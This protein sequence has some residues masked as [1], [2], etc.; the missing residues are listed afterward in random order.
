MA[1]HPGS[2]GG[3]SGNGTSAAGPQAAPSYLAPLDLA[4]AKQVLSQ[5]R[6][7]NM[8]QNRIIGNDRTPDMNVQAKL[9]AAKLPAAPNKVD[10]QI[11]TGS[12]VHIGPVAGG[13]FSTEGTSNYIVFGVDSFLPSTSGHNAA[14]G[15]TGGV[16][17]PTGLSGSALFVINNLF[18]AAPTVAG[19]ALSASSVSFGYSYLFTNAVNTE[20]YA[21]SRE[22]NLYC[23]TLPTLASACPGTWPYSAGSSVNWSAP[24]PLFSA[25]G[26]DVAAVYFGDDSGKF[27]CVNAAGATAGQSCWSGGPATLSKTPA[28]LGPPNG[29]QF[30]SGTEALF[31]GDD[32]GQMYRVL[33]TGV[34]PVAGT[35]NVGVY[36]L[37]GTTTCATNPWAVRTAPVVDYTNN[38]VYAIAGGQAFSFP[39]S[40]TIN[41]QPDATSK[42][43]FTGANG[44]IE[45]GL[46]ID[47]TNNW[48]YFTARSNLYKFSIPF[49]G[50]TTGN[51]F[52]TPL[53]NQVTSVPT[54]APDFPGTSVGTD[55]FPIGYPYPYYDSIYVG[56]GQNV[57]TGSVGLVEQYGCQASAAAPALDSTSSTAYGA[58]INTGFVVDNVAGNLN[59][60]FGTGG[61][62]PTGGFVQ[63]PAGSPNPSGWSCPS[64]TTASSTSSCGSPGCVT[65]ST[66]CTDAST[67]PVRANATATCT[68]G[69]CGFTCNTGFADCNGNATDGCE[70]NTSTDINNCGGCSATG[71]T[72]LGVVCSTVN[73]TPTCTGGVCGG[74]CNTGFS[75]CGGTNTGCTS[76]IACGKGT[77]GT[78][79][80]CGSDCGQGSTCNSG[81]AC[82]SCS[83]GNDNT[84]GC[85]TLTSLPVVCATVSEGQ[86]ATLSCAE[87]D[88]VITKVDFVS[89]GTPSG[90]CGNFA[91]SSCDA[92]DVQTLP[93]TANSAGVTLNGQNGTTTETEAQLVQNMCLGQHSCSVVAA[94][95]TAQGPTPQRQF[96]QPCTGQKFL[97]IQVEC[98]CPQCE[99]DN[100]CGTGQKCNTTAH[101]CVT[102]GSNTTCLT[103]ADCTTAGSTAC[104]T[105][106]KC[107][108]CIDDSTCGTGTH[109]DTTNNTCVACVGNSNCGTTTPVCATTSGSSS[110]YACVACVE[111]SDCTTGNCNQTT[112]TCQTCSTNAD[113]SGTMPFCNGSACV[114]C[115]ASPSVCTG[116]TPSCLADGSCGCSTATSCDSGY[117]TT[118]PICSNPGADGSSC[119]GCTSD[120][121][122]TSLNGGATP[123]CKANGVCYCSANASCTDITIGF[124][125][126]AGH[127]GCKT[128]SGCRNSGH[129]ANEICNTSTSLCGP[130]STSSQCV[131]SDLSICSTSGGTS[132]QCISCQ[133]AGGG[134]QATADSLC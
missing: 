91:T 57:S 114:G 132:G 79:A 74:T 112:H 29:V 11:T 36:S 4:S 64:G 110:S 115:S 80:C 60:G 53:V 39:S 126:T 47:G 127:C 78:S 33:D 56:T 133:T 85:S 125:C 70:V 28:V 30:P 81:G 118:T 105:A 61:T 43:V 10:W 103:S 24:F 27:H 63:Y 72:P 101:T 113:C 19:S 117:T 35:S 86:T 75:S 52:S 73:I 2:S 89:Y 87:A 66:T 17:N 107:V 94:D 98:A 95:F 20:V 106:G 6:F 82:V 50:T 102:Q 131:L 13:D 129:T 108:A 124:Q 44:P 37:C 5:H 88:Q 46:G 130:C 59:F 31:V 1:D 100:D 62:N 65:A 128:D 9:A 69:T 32:G 84:G 48:A 23:L 123:N 122:C 15:I 16:S 21:L 120:S 121:Q 116:S 34:T 41:W 14:G 68:G 96:G 51:V 90:S 38:H 8:L 67:C 76:T 18:T 3:G 7:S 25:T 58:I 77:G 49:D 54:N 119:T 92:A 26:R 55:S 12:P 134:S 99:A 109:C 22:G 42:T 45:C 71:S 93:L 104:S 111:T 40:S 83:P 97:N